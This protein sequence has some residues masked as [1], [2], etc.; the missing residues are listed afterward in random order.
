M[1]QEAE[2]L[3]AVTGAAFGATPQPTYL[4]SPVLDGLAALAAQ[5]APTA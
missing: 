2:R 5:G 1:R 4:D 3:L